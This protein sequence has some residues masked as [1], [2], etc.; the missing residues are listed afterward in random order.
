[1]LMLLRFLA[2]VLKCSANALKYIYFS[3]SMGKVTFKSNAFLYYISILT[4]TNIRVVIL[5]YSLKSNKLH[6]V[7]CAN[8]Y[9]TFVCCF[10][11]C[12]GLG[13]FFAFLITKKSYFWHM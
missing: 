2:N 13:C 9:V 11:T 1:M 6:Y 3:I 10:L 7:L 8:G 5:H 4:G 12:A